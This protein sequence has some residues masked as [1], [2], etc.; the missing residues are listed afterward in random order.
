MISRTE[1]PKRIGYSTGMSAGSV[2]RSILPTKSAGELHC[3]SKAAS[4][5]KLPITHRP[6]SAQRRPTTKTDRA[7]CLS[8]LIQKITDP[9][10]EM[11]L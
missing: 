5:L 11:A 2:P 3:R 1:P 10:G 9:G 4:L 7:G 8:R 6:R